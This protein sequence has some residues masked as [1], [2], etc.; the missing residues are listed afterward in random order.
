MQEQVLEEYGRREVNI[1]LNHNKT[2]ANYYAAYYVPSTVINTSYAFI[3]SILN[4]T[5]F[6]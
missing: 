1:I 2:I 6:Y 4:K 3:I 5:S